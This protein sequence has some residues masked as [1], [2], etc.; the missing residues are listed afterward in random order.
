MCGARDENERLIQ[1][2]STWCECVEE[3]S[4]LEANVGPKDR[5]RNFKCSR[6]YM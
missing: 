6:G 3:T 2:R 1:E 4:S 5:G